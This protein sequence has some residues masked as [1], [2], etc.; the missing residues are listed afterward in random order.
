MAAKMFFVILALAV[1]TAF[2]MASEEDDFA[3]DALY[4]MVKRGKKGRKSRGSA[5]FS[6]PDA[7]GNSGC[8]CDRRLGPGADP[9]VCR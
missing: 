4:E 1:L 8:V 2:V 3:D 6:C 9:V 7:F 5:Y